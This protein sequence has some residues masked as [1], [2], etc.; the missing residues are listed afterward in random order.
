MATIKHP[1]V[2]RLFDKV[3][4]ICPETSSRTCNPADPTLVTQGKSKQAVEI[5]GEYYTINWCASWGIEVEIWYA[6][7]EYD[8]PQLIVDYYFDNYGLYVRKAKQGDLK[9][10]SVLLKELEKQARYQD[11]A[12]AYSR[13]RT[14]GA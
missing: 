11:E 8:R 2:T 10:L 6:P 3:Q 4:E 13:S 9:L 14:L 12:E 1:S 7:S 5:R